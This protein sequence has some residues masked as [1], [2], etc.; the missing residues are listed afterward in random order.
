MRFD[1]LLAKPLA[2]R[3]ASRAAYNRT[4]A[5]AKIA[6]APLDKLDDRMLDSIARSHK[7]PVAELQSLLADRKAR[8]AGMADPD[9]F[10]GLETPL[11]EEPLF[12]VESGWAK[13][14]R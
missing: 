7:V 9:I 8:S 1:C 10:A 2:H 5:F 4:Q 11:N 13:G 3:L 14:S 6:I 12:F